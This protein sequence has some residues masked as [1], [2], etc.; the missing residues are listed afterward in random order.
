MTIP[1]ERRDSF[2]LSN[3]ELDDELLKMTDHYTEALFSKVNGVSLVFPVSRLVVDPERFENDAVEPMTRKGMGVLY[4]KTHDQRVMRLPGATE[5]QALLDQFYHRH[6]RALTDLVDAHLDQQGTA[7]IIDCHSF[8]SQ[9]LPYQ[10]ATNASLFPQIC[11]GTDPFHT[12]TSLRDALLVAFAEEGFT[13]GLNH[14]FAGTIT[15][16]KH[17]QSDRRVQSIM[18]EIRRDLYMCEDTGERSPA[19][20]AVRDMLGSLINGHLNS[21]KGNCA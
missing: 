8:H 16:L 7:L 15:P 17:Y 9:P 5:R 6:H 12:P 1:S 10:D 19:F 3:E 11:I 21:S 2:L 14:P 13:V 20:T 4:T 18:I